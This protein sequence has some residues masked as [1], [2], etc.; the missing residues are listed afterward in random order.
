MPVVWKGDEVMFRKKYVVLARRFGG[1][2]TYAFPI[3]L[4]RTLKGAKELGW[5][6]YKWRDGKYYPEI[7]VDSQYIEKANRVELVS[8]YSCQAFRE[9]YLGANTWEGIEK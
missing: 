9:E 4:R 7:Y 3:G 8:V 2:E 6:Y 1:S 5:Y